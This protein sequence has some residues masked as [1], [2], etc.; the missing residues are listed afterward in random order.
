M[1]SLILLLLALCGLAASR[2]LP[3]LL[4]ED[5]FNSSP[6]DERTGRAVRIFSGY[7]NVSGFTA[8]SLQFATLQ[9]LCRSVSVR[10]AALFAQTVQIGK[11]SSCLLLVH[12]PGAT[13]LFTFSHP[14]VI[15]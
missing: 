3:Q 8:I 2:S 13:A 15:P 5:Q 12:I 7:S 11:S 9:E 14:V 6:S 1:H 4:T 10:N